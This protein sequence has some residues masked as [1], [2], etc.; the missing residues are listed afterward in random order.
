MGNGVSYRLVAAVVHVQLS[1]TCG[2]YTSYFI[3]HKHNQWFHADDAKVK[4]II[5]FL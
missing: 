3:D 1:V 4:L 2:H 5:T